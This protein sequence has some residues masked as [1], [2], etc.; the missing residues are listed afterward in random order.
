MS[1]CFAIMPFDAQFVAVD[2]VVEEA[3]I[4]CGLE[5]R[6]GDL[7]NGPGVVMQQI[8]HEIEGAAVVVADVTTG[9]PNVFYELG[10]AHQIKGA[11]RVVIITQAIDGE[12]A[13]DILHLRQEVYALNRLALAE[14]RKNLPD[15]LRR[16][17]DSNA[18]KYTWN[19]IRGRKP[20]TLKLTQDLERLVSAAEPRELSHITI[21]IVASLSSLAISEQ[22]PADPSVDPEYFK[23]LLAERNAL[24]KVLLHGARLKA[25]LNPPRRLT[26]AMLPE[27]LRVRYKRL[28]DLLE[29]RSDISDP[30]AAAEDLAAVKNC[31]F[32]LSPVPMPNLFIIG[33]MAAYEG[34]K[35]GGAGGF[36]MTHCEKNVVELGGLIL[37]FD[38]LFEDSRREMVRA[39]PPDG[40]FLE[41]LRKHYLEATLQE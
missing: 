11:D 30:D 27:R 12:K 8:V 16:A 41:Q 29:G 10:I 5:Y 4:E 6:R 21:R 7:S 17:A 20:R 18:D 37:Q 9:N 14:L 3:A 23:A 32:A 34:M 19:I 28:I 31:E 25:V 1:T 26:R 24:R 38:E 33:S 13:F 15:L 40:Q 35:R 39:R 22:E 2:R 36:E